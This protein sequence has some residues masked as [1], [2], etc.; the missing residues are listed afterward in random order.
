MKSELISI[1]EWLKRNP[2]IEDDIE[3]TK[4]RCPDCD[5]DGWI[6]C[7]KCGHEAR[8]E[9]CNGSGQKFS[10]TIENAYYKQVGKDKIKW[11]KYV[12]NAA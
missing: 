5:G 12:I 3:D 9:S 1:K 10:N 11:K 6:E 7:S 4:T 8:C 2:E